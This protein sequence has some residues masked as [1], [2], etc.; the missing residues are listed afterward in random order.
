MEL[1]RKIFRY[2]PDLSGNPFPFGLATSYYC[3]FADDH[4]RSKRYL[5]HLFGLLA[6]R[7]LDENDVSAELQ[8]MI[9]A[10]TETSTYALCFTILILA[11]YPEIQKNVQKELD[12][13]FGE[14]DR[15][16]TLED[17]NNMEY[18]ERVIKESLRF[19]PPIPFVMRYV[20]E[21][22]E[23]GTSVLSRRILILLTYFQILK[24]FQLDQTLS[25][26]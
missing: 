10:G 24:C 20:E 18:M 19:F 22:I 16:P 4:L 26:P 8:N 1:K 2:E 11:M 6:E 3:N 15:D 17:V 9:V 5:N 13:L 14:S 7:K 25:F 21:T 23:I 12:S